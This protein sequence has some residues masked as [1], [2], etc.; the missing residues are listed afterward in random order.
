MVIGHVFKAAGKV[1]N[2]TV[3]KGSRI[4][5]DK[6]V[7]TAQGIAGSRP[8]KQI[9]VY[10]Y[11]ALKAE[12]QRRGRPLKGTGPQGGN[13]RNDKV[14][15]KKLKEKKAKISKVIKSDKKRILALR[16]PAKERRLTKDEMIKYNI[17][18]GSSRRDVPRKYEYTESR[19]NPTLHLKKYKGGKLRSY[20]KVTPMYG[21]DVKTVDM[22]KA[23]RLWFY[24][25]VNAVSKGKVAMDKVEGYVIEPVK[26]IQDRTV[27]NFERKQYEKESLLGYKGDNPKGATYWK[28]NDGSKMRAGIGDSAVLGLKAEGEQSYY[29]FNARKCCLCI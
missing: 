5:V 17:S 1:V 19:N 9:S 18:P 24:N 2:K 12:R 29:L 4:Q 8:V 27:S 14:I 23:K 15:D 21:P 6:A 26:D 16:L 28:K 13:T 3:P 7:K 10:E 11:G 22:D 25:E 20:E